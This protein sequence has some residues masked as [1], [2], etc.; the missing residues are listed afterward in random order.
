MVFLFAKE[1]GS[2]A[3]V[4]YTAKEKTVQKMT[5]DGLTEEHIG[6]G[7]KK[8]VPD[9]SRGR[10]SARFGKRVREAS[11]RQEVSAEESVDGSKLERR[12]SV[13]GDPQSRQRITADSEKVRNRS[14]KIRDHETVPDTDGLDGQKS[15]IKTRQKKAR[16]KEEQAKS[17]HLA[18]DDEG[19]QMV[20]GAGMGVGRKAAGAAAS[21][22]SVY[23]HVKASEEADD[24]AAVN[25]ASAGELMTERAAVSLKRTQDRSKRAD[26]RSGRQGLH[27]ESAS[28]SRLKFTQAG[29]EGTGSTSSNKKKQEDRQTVMNRFFQRKR[30]KEAYQ[31]ARSGAS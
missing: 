30:Y 29:Q 5:R 16:L 19:S 10:P 25:A 2:L 14:E 4:K 11:L 15:Q 27:V 7:Q 28:E 26:V 1:V 9:K 21:A 17:G 8:D 3:G 13:D 20:R 6:D 22:A 23:V 31:S 18:F 24:N 12:I